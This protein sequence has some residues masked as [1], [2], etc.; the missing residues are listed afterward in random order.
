MEIMMEILKGKVEAM[1]T[2]WSDAISAS[3]DGKHVVDLAQVF[4][5]LFCSNIVH[6]CFGEDV[7]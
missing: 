6:I 7:S 1:V 3:P 4:E 5:K 2:K